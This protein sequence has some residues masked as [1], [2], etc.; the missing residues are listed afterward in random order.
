MLSVNI[1]NSFLSRA[2]LFAEKGESQKA[3]GV[4]ETVL[5]EALR[6]LAETR[7]ISLDQ[8]CSMLKAADALHKAD[9]IPESTRDSIA[10]LQ[11]FLAA[12]PSEKREGG[13]FSAWHGWAQKFLYEHLGSKIVIV[14]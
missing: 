14:N 12:G 11:A 5:C 2:L 9:A 1:F 7:G 8:T 6:K 13:D 10:E 4:L 3:L